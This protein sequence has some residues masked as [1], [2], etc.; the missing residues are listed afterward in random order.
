MSYRVTHCSGA[1]EKD[2]PVDRFGEL[3]DELVSAD[4]EHFD[5]SVCHESEWCLSLYR[6]HVAVLEQLEGGASMHSAPLTRDEAL[7]LMAK[8]ARGD[9]EEL[10]TFPWKPGYP[11][12]MPVLS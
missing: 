9:I 2:F 3:L 6:S 5:I 11:P 12:A 4:S 10:L 8:V 7:S 1:T